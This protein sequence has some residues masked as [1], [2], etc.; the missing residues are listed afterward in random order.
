MILKLQMIPIVKESIK[1]KEQANIV[2]IRLAIVVVGRYKITNPAVLPNMPY[3][4]WLKYKPASSGMPAHKEANKGICHSLSVCFNSKNE[5]MTLRIIWPFLFGNGYCL[6]SYL[7]LR[8]YVFHNCF[9]F[10]SVS[11]PAPNHL[12]QQPWHQ[13]P[14]KKPAANSSFAIVGLT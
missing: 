5:V 2:I 11:I 1:P 6:W 12:K 7:L 10:T 9:S 4:I 3:P 14:K 13:R 8:R